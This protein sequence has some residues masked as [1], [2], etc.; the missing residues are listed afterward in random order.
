M[1]KATLGWLLLLGIGFPL[2]GLLLNEAVERLEHK[3]PSLASALRKILNYVLPPL[4]LLLLLQQLLN[5]ASTENSSRLISTVFWVAVIAAGL[6]LINALLTTTTSDTSARWQLQVPNL[7]FQ[8]ARTA[9]IVAIGYYLVA[10][11]WS[12][13]L[14]GIVT[15]VGVS[16]LVVAL[17]LQSTLSNLVSG[18]LLLFAKPFKPG[19]WI[20]FDGIEG[21]VIAQ[22]WWS[23][24]IEHCAWEKTVIVPNGALAGA[25]IDNFSDGGAWKSVE[26]EFSYDDPP[27]QVLAELSKINQGIEETGLDKFFG[28]YGPLIFPLIKEF[29]ASGITYVVWY[30]K[31]PDRKNGAFKTYFLSRIYYMAKRKGFTIPYPISMQYKLEV[32]E[33]PGEIPQVVED[34]QDSVV[35]HLRSLPYFHSLEPEDIVVLAAKASIQQY[36]VNDVIVQE[37]QLDDGF[38]TLMKGQVRVWTKNQ[39]GVPSGK[40]NLTQGDAFGEMALFPGE[41][42][43]ITVVVEEDADIVLLNAAEIVALI[44]S[45]SKFGFEM[46]RFIESRRRAL[47]IAKGIVEEDDYVFSNG[48]AGHEVEINL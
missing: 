12:V 14:S 16:S 46:T 41:L 17:A 34:H 43:P 33:L 4:A 39:Q 7:F 21:R 13:D 30:K 24:T 42:S 40:H 6:S 37:D 47:N 11:V 35:A 26:I 10:G 19:D 5:V 2:L 15:A 3:Q 48:R 23:V 1:D 18:L 25:K 44:Q 45:K 9:V 38:Y 20:A 27:Y 29:G 28:N 32:D 8:V 36:G 31:I 22:N